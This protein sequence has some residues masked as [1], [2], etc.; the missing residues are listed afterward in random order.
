MCY[1]TIRRDAHNR[2][3]LP[4]LHHA[5]ACKHAILHSLLL[6]TGLVVD[7][8]FHNSQIPHNSASDNGISGEQAY[9]TITYEHLTAIVDSYFGASSQWYNRHDA[10]TTWYGSTTNS[11]LLLL[12]SSASSSSSSRLQTTDFIDHSFD[13][14]DYFVYFDH[15]DHFPNFPETTAAST[16]AASTTTFRPLLPY[17]CFDRLFRHCTSSGTVPTSS[18]DSPA[19][20]R[21]LPVPTSSSDTPALLRSIP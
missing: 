4:L 11:D 21:S 2:T 17:H 12:F 6:S 8:L 9:S 13:Y 19:L 10:L 5:Y 18:S 15:F 16:T 14:F 3:P 1:S 20:L 7:V